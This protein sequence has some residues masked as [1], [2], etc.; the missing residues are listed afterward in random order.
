MRIMFGRNIP[1]HVPLPTEELQQL[2][3][4]KN[5]LSRSSQSTEPAASEEALVRRVL[6]DIGSF[7]LFRWVGM[8]F[9]LHRPVLRD[10]RITPATLPAAIG[11]RSAVRSA[12]AATGRTPDR[13]AHPITGYAA[14]KC[15]RSMRLRFA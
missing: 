11:W 13:K 2:C 6:F 12:N 9:M 14:L 10:F 1:D 7:P 8:M 4:S 3:S 5:S 15:R